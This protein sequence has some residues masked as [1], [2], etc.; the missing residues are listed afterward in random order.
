MIK[1]RFS[2][3]TKDTSPPKCQLP[4]HYKFGEHTGLVE[5]VSPFHKWLFPS[6]LPAPQAGEEGTSLEQTEQTVPWE[7]SDET[8]PR[9]SSPGN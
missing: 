5:T 4:V 7:D 3:F 9:M 6:F 8:S 1:D 2:Y